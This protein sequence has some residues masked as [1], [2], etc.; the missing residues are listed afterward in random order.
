MSD[1]R[2]LHEATL[3]RS[4]AL[5]E[6]RTSLVIY[7]DGATTVVPL[8]DET[9]VV[10]GRAAPA[11][12]I[13]A[14]EKLSRAHARFTAVEDGVLVEDL[15]STNGTHHRGKR[16][17]RVVLTPGDS[18]TL[19]R[20]TV[21]VSQAEGRANLLGDFLSYA[22]LRER[23]RD[24]VVRTR[25]FRR[26]VTVLFVREL[27]EGGDVTSWVSKVRAALRPVDRMALFGANGAFAML[28][29]TD[30]ARARVVAGR[31]VELDERL[32]VGVALLGS[33]EAEL[34]DAARR[35]ARAASASER[36]V[37]HAHDALVGAGEPIFA[38]PA[39]VELEELL[40]RVA[41]STIG[42]LLTGESGAGKEVVAQ[43]I[44]RRGARA[45]GPMRV[46][47][48]G[49][50]PPDR[51]AEAL[52][53]HEAGAFEGAGEARDGLLVEARGGTLFFDAIDE[54]GGEAQGALLRAIEARVVRRIGGDEDVPIDVRVI[55]ATREDPAALARSG[56]LRPDLLYRLEGIRIHVP[57]LRERPGDLDPL[58]DRFLAE[59][60]AA[61]GARVRG[62]EPE[63]RAAL[64]AH[65][66]PGNVRELRNA[67]ERA[68]VACTAELVRLEDLPAEVRP[69]ATP[70]APDAID[71][72]AELLSH[73]ERL[74][75]QAIERAA[76]NA[77]QAARLLSIPERTLRRKATEHGLRDQL[78]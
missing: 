53:G 61:A 6:A 10:L 17:E 46:L 51:V 41:R 18:V 20:V 57:P 27:G 7:T 69:A 47:H 59:A 58:I 32:V 8:E 22:E 74:L 50:M 9:P 19:G 21:S 54:L 28:P 35:A 68:V 75:R 78:V 4:R 13:V 14:E 44:H 11:D 66:W 39:M 30:E 42:V 67:I 15:G 56:R 62:V 43:A 31:I 38:D 29:E 5:G 72:R 76:G 34:V 12:V 36:V 25:T 60:S 73:E 1:Q 64:H 48:C 71:L 49:A 3:A 26:G 2:T 24:E 40:E 33:T 63:A 16:V 55:A 45:Q 77:E 52:F 70:E 23:L 37:V 65:R